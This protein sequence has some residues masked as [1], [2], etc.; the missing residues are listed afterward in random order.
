MNVFKECAMIR[1]VPR[2]AATEEQ[3]VEQ[4]L[5]I[6]RAASELHQEGGLRALSV[7]AVARRAGVSTGLLYSYY[8]N[9]SDLTRSLWSAPIAHLGHSLA[10]V[11]QTASA[12]GVDPITRVERLLQTYVDFTITNDET[13]RGL[14]LFVR[15]PDS[16]TELNN[17]PDL[18]ML[19]A[20][21]RRA[22]EAGQATGVIRDGDPRRL[23][24]LLWSGVHGALA[25]PINID[26]YDLIDGP[27]MATEMIAALTRSITTVTSAGNRAST[28]NRTSKESP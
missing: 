10:A 14:L 12:D 22:V 7:R 16:T 8:A 24:Q 5:R 9:M 28:G 15:S 1:G 2:P 6:R 19:F 23:A 13:H 17:D 11:E 25:L 20:S 3:R 4:R 18:L 27:T 21:L 26:T